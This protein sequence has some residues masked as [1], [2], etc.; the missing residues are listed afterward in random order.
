MKDK[1]KSPVDMNYKELETLLDSLLAREGF[2]AEINYRS[3]MIHYRRRNMVLIIV[4]ALYRL[5]R[6]ELVYQNY[7]RKKIKQLKESKEIYNALKRTGCL[8]A[9]RMY[10]YLAK[11]GMNDLLSH[12][13]GRFNDKLFANFTL[14]TQLYDASFDVLE[15]QK[16]LKDFDAFIM[17]GKPIKSNDVF[18]RVFNECVDYLKQTLNK[19]EFDTFQRFVQ[20]EHLSQLMSIYQLSDKDLSRDSLRKITF[21]KGGIALLAILYIM[22]PNMKEKEKKAIY[23]LGSV[24]Q[25][26]DDIRDT[27]EDL[28][29]GI[30]TLPNQKV[31]YYHEL[32]SMF[33][34]TVNNLIEQCNMSPDQPNGT[35]DMLYWFSDAL[36]EKRYGAYLLKK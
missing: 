27:K 2:P 3:D 24:L 23:E 34:G 8:K 5:I 31:L 11:I 19:Q 13:G 18:L 22:T 1:K 14:G 26:I 6:A 16:Y 35:L 17:T 21:S 28:Q 7:L 30:Q 10:L 29:G 36:L 4:K 9:I 12:L 32:K 20:I 25:I 33:A 15:C